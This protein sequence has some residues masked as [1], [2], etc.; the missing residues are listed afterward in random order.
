MSAR[1]DYIAPW[2]SAYRAIRMLG[3]AERFYPR[4]FGHLAGVV[5][6]PGVG[7]YRVT[8]PTAHAGESG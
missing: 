8:G 4:R 2:K 6:P 5:T 7:R 1:E 3:G